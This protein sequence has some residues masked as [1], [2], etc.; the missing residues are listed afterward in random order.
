MDGLNIAEIAAIFGSLLFLTSFAY[1]NRKPEAKADLLY[2]CINLAAA[3]LMLL[4]LSEYWNIG[5]LINNVAWV[6]ISLFG[7]YKHIRKPTL[8]AQNIIQ[9]KS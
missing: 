7:L 8:Q 2:L 9:T 1:L 4:S 5:V 3:A 6:V